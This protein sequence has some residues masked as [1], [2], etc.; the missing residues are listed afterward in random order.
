MQHI[1]W[2]ITNQL[3]GRCGPAAAA[4]DLFAWKEAGISG[5]VSLDNSGV[6][7]GQIEA[8]GLAHLPIYYPMI[9]LTSRALQRDFVQRL[10]IIL[11][12]VD[13][14]LSKGGKVVVHCYHGMDRTG[15]VLACY[16]V[17]QFGFTANE[18]IAAVRQFR[19]SALSAYGY[20]Q[21]VHLFAERYAATGQ[22][23]SR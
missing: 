23:R 2:V 18:A 22:C 17:R 16:L 9:E 10:P 4:W 3:G 12:F 21:A 15:A 6:F 11:T 14:H 8:A 7:T 1:Y 13:E 20:A 5:I 19:P